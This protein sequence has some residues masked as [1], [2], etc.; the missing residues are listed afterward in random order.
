MTS[1]RT[2][3]EKLKA[4]TARLNEARMRLAALQEE[5]RQS[6]S[7]RQAELDSV[8]KA[9]TQIAKNVEDMSEL[10]SKLDREVAARTDLGAYEKKAAEQPPAPKTRTAAVL[11]PNSASVAMLSPGRIKPDIPFVEAKGQLQLPAQGRRVLGLRRQ[12][13]ARDRIEGARHPDAPRRASR[14]AVRRLDRLR[15]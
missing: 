10:I 9:A 2:E 11:A 5:K 8:L 6:Q 1:I 15:R 4:E 7:E 3:S 12:D 13:A 14:V